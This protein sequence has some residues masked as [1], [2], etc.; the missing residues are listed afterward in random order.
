MRVDA[1][2]AAL[3]LF[4]LC[5]YLTSDSGM[6]GTRRTGAAIATLGH[7]LE[8]PPCPRMDLTCKDPH[9]MDSAWGMSC[10]TPCFSVCWFFLVTVEAFTTF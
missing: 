2:L 9:S 6:D 8:P 3:Q 5:V 4:D 10:L 7:G 1:V